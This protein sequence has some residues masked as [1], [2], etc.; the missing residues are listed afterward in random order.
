MAASIAHRMTGN[1]LAV[2]GLIGL[3]WW[4]VAAASGK[5]SYDYFLSWANHWSGKIVLIGL[6]WAFFQHLLSGLRHFVM[7]AGAGYELNINRTWSYMVF[8]GGIILTGAF[9]L[10]LTWKGL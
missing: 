5:E 10:A 8:A 1:A 3:V 7:D 9:W 4:L 2:A 6:T